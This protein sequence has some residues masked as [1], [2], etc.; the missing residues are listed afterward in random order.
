MSADRLIT[1]HLLRH[2][3][4]YNP[5]RIIYGRLP[6]YRLSERGHAMADLA[7]EATKA[8]PV[9]LVVA[10]PL[11]RAQQTAQPVAAGHGLPLYT[12]PRVIE[13]R[14]SFEG[15]RLGHGS[16]RLSNPRTLALLRNPFR[17]SWGEPYTTL[18][19]RMHE[20][21]YAAVAASRRLTGGKDVVIASH[22]LPIWMARRGFEGAPL[23]HDPRRREC[24]LAS[25]T[26]FTF[27]GDELMAIS[28][29]EPA[30][31]LYPGSTGG[32][33]A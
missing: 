3:E 11:V 5:E 32:V 2:G 1:V 23:P 4:V 31:A 24:N 22:Q 12:D 10:S 28:Y 6:G 18:V 7:A 33:G 20:A 16:A 9:G 13:A 27:S 17:P 8:F 26:S 29:S 14:N 30:A 21:V 19:R 15:Q 25:L